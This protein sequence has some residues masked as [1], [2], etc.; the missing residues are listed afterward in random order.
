MSNESKP[1]ILVVDDE[2]SICWAFSQLFNAQ[3]WQSLSAASAEEGLELAEA[4]RPDLVLLD[5]RLP[6]LSGLDALPKFRALNPELPI[7]VMTAHGTMDTAIEATRRGAFNYLTKPIH[8]DDAL[9][10]IRSALERR[11]LSREVAQLRRELLAGAG[12]DSMIGKS[13][14]MQEV[15]K[16]IGAVAGAESSVLILGESGSGKELVARAIHNYSARSR[17]PFVAVNC[18]ALPEQLLESELYGHVK[19]AFTG[20]IRDKEGKAET[21]RGG[22]LFLDEIGEMPLSV[23]AKLLRFIEEKKFE[24]VGST[25]SVE[26]DVRILAATNLDLRTQ[27]K[28]QLFREDLYYRLNV[29]SIELPPL[30]RRKDDLPL[31]VASFLTRGTSRDKAMPAEAQGI[32]KDAM[33]LIER[34]DW[35]GNVREL[36]NAIEHAVIVSR[37]AVIL[38]EHLP[39]HILRSLRGE[40]AAPARSLEELVRERTLAALDK[41]EGRE[42]GNAYAEI[43]SDVE[44]ALLDMTLKRVN[45]NQVKASALLGI[46]RTTLRKKMEEFGL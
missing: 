13:P 40:D 42:E 23:Q 45:G 11:N 43:V 25:E 6:G 35:P 36:R 34:Y 14:E 46:H 18:A 12:L 19:G 37:G 7:L 33:G 22:T 31:L 32:S 17:G 29:V 30:R 4:E 41:A 9:H 16:K 38:P 21:A 5:I 8:N 44:R 2:P 24:R 39:A 27:I 1:K 28:K 10:Q 26:A 15:Y 3:G 20:A